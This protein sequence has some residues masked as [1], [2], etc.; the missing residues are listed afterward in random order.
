MRGLPDG[1]VGT[2]LIS[3]EYLILIQLPD[4]RHQSHRDKINLL[5]LLL[6]LVRLE[7]LLVKPVLIAFRCV[8]YNDSIWTTFESKKST[9]TS[10]IVQS[11]LA[12]LIVLAEVSIRPASSLHG[13]SVRNFGT[14]NIVSFIASIRCFVV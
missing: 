2:R 3:G 4:W 9:P 6:Q 11:A 13:S 14:T 7:K 8:I 1:T 5:F 12:S 10:S